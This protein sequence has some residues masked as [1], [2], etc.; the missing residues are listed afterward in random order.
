MSIEA[1][2]VVLPAGGGG[3]SAYPN[4]LSGF[5]GPLRGEV[6]GGVRGRGKEGKRR[7]NT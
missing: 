5:E 4:H 2:N 3:N 1:P 7:K 6:K